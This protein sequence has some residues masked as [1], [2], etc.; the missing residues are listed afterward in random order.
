MTCQNNL[1]QLALAVMGYHDVARVFPPIEAING[2]SINARLLPFLDQ[3]GMYNELNIDQ[4][5]AYG[6]RSAAPFEFWQCPQDAGPRS[7]GVNYGVNIGTGLFGTLDGVFRGSNVSQGIA[8]ITDGTSQTAL[9]S[10]WIRAKKSTG[11]VSR[12]EPRS[13][14]FNLKG[15]P[16]PSPS[17][18][19]TCRRIDP[20]SASIAW[21]SRGMDWLFGSGQDVS[22]TH[23]LGINEYSCSI[24]GG[25][26]AWS[27]GSDHGGG[28]NVSFADG[29]VR[30]VSENLDIRVW[31]AFATCAEGDL[32]Q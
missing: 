5:V 19:D 11:P 17:L 23:A 20:S 27:A 22:Y 29:A 28:A 2:H 30:F 14:I 13:L 10:E 6:T 21:Q 8:G 7:F 25:T 1:R 15:F 26:F 18:V 3:D 24:D 12:K 4:Q 32:T 16:G 31:R 9:M